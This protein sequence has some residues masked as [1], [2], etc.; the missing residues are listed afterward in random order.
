MRGRSQL[1]EDNYQIIT[2]V[3]KTLKDS[4]LAYTSWLFQHLLQVP[5]GP[6]GQGQNEYSSKQLTS[7]ASI[8]P[9]VG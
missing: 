2:L 4:F 3:A 8:C 6:S 7:W 9:P 1:T 5:W